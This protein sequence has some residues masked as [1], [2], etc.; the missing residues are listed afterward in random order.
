MADRKMTGQQGQGRHLISVMIPTYNAPDYFKTAL[1][2]VRAQDY[3]PLEIIVCDNSTDDRTEEMMRAAPYADDPRIVY[4]R[5]REAK[6][7]EENFAPFEHL[8]HGD[9]IQWLMH[10]DV[11]LPGKLTKMAAVLDEHPEITL[12]ASQRN[13]ID[14]DGKVID[15]WL[16]T[17]YTFPEECR[18]IPGEKAGR[19]ILRKFSN[20]IGEPSVVLFRRKDQA[21]PYYHAESRGYKRLSDVAMWLELMEKG[22]LALFREPLSSF[23]VHAAQEGQQPDVI[24]ESRLEWLR[25]A[26]EYYARNV[27]LHTEDDF[28]TALRVLLSDY[29]SLWNSCCRPQAIR[30]FS[31][32]WREKY[33]SAMAYVVKELGTTLPKTDTITACLIYRNEEA[34]LADWLT[35][36][37]KYC[38]ELVLVD[39]GST[40]GSREIVSTFAKTS[41]VT[42]RMIS[43]LWEDDFAA[44]RNTALEAA[45]SDWIVFLDADETFEHPELVPSVIVNLPQHVLGVC[46]P[47]INV[48][49]DA[50]GQE[51]GRFPALRI[52]KNAKNRRYHGRIHETLLEDG[53]PLAVMCTMAQLSVR[54]TGYSTR[55]VQG[56]IERNLALMRQ[57]L[58]AGE[59]DPRCLHRYFADC[60]YGLG[61]YENAL[62]S[63]MRAIEEEPET[64]AGKQA[65]YVRVLDA[66]QGLERPAREQLAFARAAHREHPDW[67]DMAVSEGV[68]AAACGEHAAAE[69]TLTAFLAALDEAASGKGVAFLQETGAA[70]RRPEACRTLAALRL[71]DGDAATAEDLLRQALAQ[72][73]YDEQTL[74]LWEAVCRAR[75]T[76]FLPSLADIYDA[77]KD[78][79]RA[80]LRGWVVHEGQAAYAAAFAPERTVI[81][82]E[83]A[84]QQG[85]DGAPLLFAA[86]VAG[87]KELARRNPMAYE[88][89]A[90]LL[91]DTMRRVLDVWLERPGAAL[92][93]GDDDG[94]L[95][96]IGA[97]RGRCSHAVLEDYARL[98]ASFDAGVQRRAAEKFVEQ[99]E[100]AIAFALYQM[101]PEEDVGDA[102][103]FWHALGLCLYHLH[104]PA[105]DE[106]F[107]RAEAAGCAR[108]DIAAYRAWMKA[109]PPQEVAE[110]GGKEAAQ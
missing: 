91:P 39:T 3:A 103:T 52:W 4:V 32:E 98:A 71:A 78:E 96:G 64:V 107:A 55:R 27:F 76:A 28:H 44:A 13:I 60:Y 84:V 57:S 73:R 42:M 92:A 82:C 49:E 56:K 90:A 102:A 99:E 66:M 108:R 59:Q 62:A 69:E 85:I 110:D 105:A 100:W 106:C 79:D 74:T 19:I 11:L 20:F 34:R 93:P 35:A 22:D 14:A 72:A 1:D 33:L 45:T 88:Q 81:S 46:V 65:L 94:Y 6:T 80:F 26:R 67:L 41:T 70:G 68:L 77:K 43:I 63:A 47:I 9:Y 89:S 51:I 87:G 38:D 50:G 40:D 37:V 10:D 12:V 61:D 53:Q 24:A 109:W 58:A 83:A 30:P 15:S 48:D 23:R 54:H 8:V 75:G 17:K 36:A 101:I 2:S 16:Q 21:Y 29:R 7:K 5:N 18:L 95:T 104:E 97:L 31:A 25:L 86:L